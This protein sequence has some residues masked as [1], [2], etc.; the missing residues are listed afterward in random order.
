MAEDS[1]NKRLEVIL[2]NLCN[3]QCTFCFTHSSQDGREFLR[4]EDFVKAL[5]QGDYSEVSL[6][7]GEPFFHPEFGRFYKHALDTA[8]NVEIVT[9]GSIVKIINGQNGDFGLGSSVE[10][11]KKEIAQY[12]NPRTTL[13]LSINREL[14]ETNQSLIR[15]LV[16]Y[17][18]VEEAR[19]KYNVGYCK[20]DRDQLAEEV[21][22]F[23]RNYGININPFQDVRPLV[24]LGRGE[25]L[26]SKLNRHIPNLRTI[27]DFLAPSG[28]IY[29]VSD[30]LVK[31]MRS[32]VRT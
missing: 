3:Q 2:T 7:G 31:E 5:E 27:Y 20:G 8:T 11:T 29:L 4:F 22:S 17:H 32:Y 15:A 30:Q 19:L 21:R 16:L 12:D 24:A 25:N 23:F 9:N 10:R 26:I 6:Y 13:A 18:S 1:K 14:M 28:R